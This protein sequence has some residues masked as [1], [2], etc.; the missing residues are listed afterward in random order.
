MFELFYVI[1]RKTPQHPREKCTESPNKNFIKRNVGKCI[2]LTY[3][4]GKWPTKA[5]EI[6]LQTKRTVGAVTGNPPPADVWGE[7]LALQQP[8]TSHC[9]PRPVSSTHTDIYSE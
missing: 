2:Q 4:S 5:H 3:T 8:A 7:R 6:T 9:A 1:I